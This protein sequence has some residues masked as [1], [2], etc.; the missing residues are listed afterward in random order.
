M[1]YRH[2]FDLFRGILHVFVD[3]VD[4]PEFCG[5]ATA[6]NIRSPGHINS[7]YLVM[8]GV[9]SPA[10]LALSKKKRERG[11]GETQL[12]MASKKQGNKRLAFC[13]YEKDK[14]IF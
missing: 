3:F 1:L 14:I 2:L 12:K 6:R 4:L 11:L 10:Y 8:W 7:Q 9:D 13:G 5:S